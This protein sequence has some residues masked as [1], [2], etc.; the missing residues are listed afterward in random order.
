MFQIQT[1]SAWRGASDCRSCSIR[2]AALFGDLD[3]QDFRLLHAPIDDLLFPQESTIYH[4][5]GPSQGVLTLH[6]GLIKLVH[7]TS[8]GCQRIVRVL[9]PGHLQTV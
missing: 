9:Q 3:E 2:S 6:S 8:G 7:V 5:G 1:D 4:E